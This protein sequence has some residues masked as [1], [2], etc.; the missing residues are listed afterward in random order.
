MLQPPRITGHIP[1][2]VS[3]I[4]KY[5]KVEKE[6]GGGKKGL[7]IMRLRTNH[8]GLDVNVILLVFICFMS[9]LSNSYYVRTM[10]MYN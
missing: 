1:M 6:S 5:K 7:A 10:S 4:S 9:L 2:A 8:K 3:S